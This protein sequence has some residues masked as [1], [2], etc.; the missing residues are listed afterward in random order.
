M[1]LNY[2]L[3]TD[4]VSVAQV[5]RITSPCCPFSIFMNYPCICGCTS[6][7][8]I[9]FYLAST[10]K[11]VLSAYCGHFLYPTSPLFLCRLLLCFSSLSLSDEVFLFSKMSLSLPHSS[12]RD[13]LRPPR[14]GP[15]AKACRRAH[16][17]RGKPGATLAPE[18]HITG[19]VNPYFTTSLKCYSRYIRKPWK[20]CNDRLKGC[21][22]SIIPVRNLST[23]K[24]RINPRAS[25]LTFKISKWGKLQMCALAQSQTA[26][27]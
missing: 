4:L 9:S 26:I 7:Y 21:T 17:S 1:D 12:S 10:E 6:I 18:H 20:S 23:S 25:L 15:D 14:L 16:R 3:L 5:W 2:P 8:S 19:T 11:D 27:I 22:L 13:P 24:I